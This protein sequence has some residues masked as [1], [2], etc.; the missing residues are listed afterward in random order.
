MCAHPAV[1]VDVAPQS[2]IS[3]GGSAMDSPDAEDDLSL[4]ALAPE[5]T[6]ASESKPTFEKEK[7]RSPSSAQHQSPAGAAVGSC[8]E[9]EAPARASFV[10]AGPGRMEHIVRAIVVPATLRSQTC[11]LRRRTR[12][13]RM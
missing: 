11:N 1:Q 3:L 7:G 4:I 12:F 5:G 6:L 13:S 10:K 8:L 9:E 2:S